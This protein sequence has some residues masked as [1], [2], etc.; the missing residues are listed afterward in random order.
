MKFKVGDRVIKVKNRPDCSNSC[1]KV[2]D[3]G[4]VNYVDNSG[5][6]IKFPSAR[7]FCEGFK[8]KDN[9]VKKIRG[10]MQYEDL[11]ERIEAVVAWDKDADDILQEIGGEYG[12]RIATVNDFAY[13]NIYK[14]ERGWL[15]DGERVTRLLL[16]SFTY[17]GQCEKLEAFKKALLW[18]LDHSDIKKIDSEREDTIKKLEQEL[19]DIRSKG[20][21]IW[22]AIN[23]L[24][25]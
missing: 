23:K 12:I 8:Y 24:K 22:E 10:S 20:D 6:S 25:K 13:I 5:F 15:E 9:V 18:L 1:C 4:V 7:Y 17:S 21:E 11:K 3:K 16:K 19:Y 2:G 14:G